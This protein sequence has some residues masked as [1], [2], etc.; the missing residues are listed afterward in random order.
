M[1]FMPKKKICSECGEEAFLWK[2]NP[3]LCRPCSQKI[4]ASTTTVD[5][6]KKLTSMSLAKV[7]SK[8]MIQ[9]KKDEAF[10]N[11]IWNERPHVCEEC[12]I[13]LGDYSQKIF[14]SHIISK[15][16]HQELRH[17]KLNINVL[18]GICH[19]AWEFGKRQE[20]KIYEKNKDVI[21][22]LLK[23]SIAH[24]KRGK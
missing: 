18:C 10:Y 4:L 13:H 12:G 21:L 24:F 23:E 5:G 17:N 14:F 19:S 11:E 22:L 6:A 1:T 3:K 20:M 16:S 2:S 15:G 8:G 9:I 7:S